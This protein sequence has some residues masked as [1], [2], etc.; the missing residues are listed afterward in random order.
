MSLIGRTQRRRLS[1]GACFGADLRTV[2]VQGEIPSDSKASS[3]YPN[4]SEN[5]FFMDLE[6]IFANHLNH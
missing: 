2:S 1:E 3:P 6:R 5:G 4:W